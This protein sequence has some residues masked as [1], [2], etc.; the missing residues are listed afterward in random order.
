MPVKNKARPTQSGFE[1]EIVALTNEEAKL[2]SKAIQAGTGTDDILTKTEG[3]KYYSTKAEY[4]KLVKEVPTDIIYKDGL[5]LMHDSVEITK[6]TDKVQFK[7]INGTTL[8]GKGNIVIPKGDT[9]P[10]GPQGE[11][12]PQGPAGTPGTTGKTIALFGDKSILVPST[13]TETNYDIYCHMIHIVGSPTVSDFDIYF[14]FYSSKNLEC[15]SLQDLKTVLGTTFTRSCNGIAKTK[16]AYAITELK[17]LTMSGEELLTGIT[18]ED[19]V[20]TI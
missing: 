18:I 11:R 6:Q 7:T 12:G 9:G 16:Q 1:G 15:N 5:T 17:V 2:I 3:D 20:K 14:E 13:V 8:I 10:Q 4:D 19:T